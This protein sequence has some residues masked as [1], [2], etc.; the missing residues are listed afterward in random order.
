MTLQKYRILCTKRTTL[1]SGIS[2]LMASRLTRAL[3][4]TVT[5]KNNNKRNL[6][7]SCFQSRS[8]LSVAT[9]AASPRRLD[10][11]R[12]LT[13]GSGTSKPSRRVVRAPSSNFRRK[14]T[15]SLTKMPVPQDRSRVTLTRGQSS[16]TNLKNARTCQ[17]RRF[18]LRRQS[19]KASIYRLL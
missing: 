6:I 7:S 13:L 5:S 16:T 18:R 9:L 17:S 19:P 4:S 14:A 12:T 10:S 2:P 1:T 11:P 15:P 3:I 8:R